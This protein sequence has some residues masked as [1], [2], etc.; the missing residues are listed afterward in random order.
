MNE[1]DS[2]VVS[3]IIQPAL[4]EQLKQIIAE[5]AEHEL[6]QD[7]LFVEK[8]DEEPE[9]VG[10]FISVNGENLRHIVWVNEGKEDEQIFLIGA[11]ETPVSVDPDQTFKYKQEMKVKGDELTSPVVL[12][13]L[14]MGRVGSFFNLSDLKG[15][16]DK[17][18]FLLAGH[19]MT[20]VQQVT[21][22][23]EHMQQAINYGREKFQMG[24]P[25]V[26]PPRQG[27]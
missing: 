17:Q 15:Y 10:T 3:E 2:P 16:Y 24:S 6:H 22:I 13:P 12:D 8:Q 23:N 1:T 4:K 11:F 19:D 7:I 18:G 5:D 26:P 9:T 27:Q 21:R 20:N 25:T 14:Y